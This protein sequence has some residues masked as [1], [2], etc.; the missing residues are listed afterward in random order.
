MHKGIKVLFITV[1]VVLGFTR[2]LFRSSGGG[3]RANDVLIGLGL[4]I[5]AVAVLDAIVAVIL[6]ITGHA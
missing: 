3:F 2:L 1:A 4:I 5:L 6:F